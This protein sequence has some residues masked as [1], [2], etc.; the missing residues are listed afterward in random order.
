MVAVHKVVLIDFK[1][2]NDK[3]F[4]IHKLQILVQIS[5]PNLYLLKWS[6]LFQDELPD[7]SINS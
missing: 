3:K 6:F 2:M 7:H 1:N 4:F 5:P